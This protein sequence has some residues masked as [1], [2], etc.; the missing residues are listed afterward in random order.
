MFDKQII[1]WECVNVALTQREKEILRLIKKNPMIS[2]EEL[3]KMLGISRSAVAGHIANLMKKGFILGRG[4]VVRDLKGV[5]VI[6]GANIDIKGKPYKELRQHTSNPG[7]INI[8]P[9]GVGRNI[10]HN[11]AQLNVP[12]TFLSVVGNDDEG[13]RLLEETR[14]AG[15]NVEQVVISNTRRTGIYLA[16]LNAIGDM[17]IALSG[18]D[19]LEELNIQYLESKTEVIKN[20]EIVVFDANIPEESIRYITELCYN[21]NIPVVVEP[22][23]IDKA[24]KL[25]NV[26]DKIDY[27]TPNKEELESITEIN[28]LNDEDMKK[29]VKYLRDKGIKNVIVTLGERGVYVSSEELEKFIEPYQTEIV[30]ATGAGDALTAGLVYGIFNGYSLEVSA[31]L[32]LAAASLTISSPYTVNPFLNENQLKNIVKEI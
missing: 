14:Q 24:K 7:H 31:K 17:D 11:L 3:A 28:I 26:L 20:S 9:G 13:R 21:N 4:Y 32:G 6:G 2:Q 27:I 29:A 8:A 5:T 12:V 16:I 1:V 18:M 30:D 25:K 19:I 15:V 10:A 22:V 23:S